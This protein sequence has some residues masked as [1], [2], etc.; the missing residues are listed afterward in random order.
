MQPSRDFSS[1]HGAVDLGAMQAAAQRRERAAK[2]AGCIRKPFCAKEQHEDHNE[3]RTVPAL[4]QTSKHLL[5]LS[6]GR[7]P[8]ICDQRGSKASSAPR[9]S[10]VCSSARAKSR[11]S[12]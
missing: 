10:E 3:Q 8:S 12:S 5:R 11:T 6:L 7:A 1:L 4:K 9:T 2:A